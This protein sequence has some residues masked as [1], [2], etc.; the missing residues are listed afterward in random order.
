[1]RISSSIDALAVAR[2]ES[3]V[4]AARQRVGQLEAEG[5]RILRWGLLSAAAD[6]ATME[7]AA[8][9][10]G[11]SG[12]S[13]GAPAERLAAS[14][15]GCHVA[16]VIPTGLGAD[17]GGFVGDAGPVVRALEAVADTVI[18]NPNSVNGADFYGG[19][20]RS[21]YVEGWLLDQF[22]AGRATLRRTPAVRIGLLL[23]RLAPSVHHRLIDAANGMIAVRGINVMAVAA[24]SEALVADVRRSA[25]GHFIGTVGNLEVLLEP[26]R[27]LI[28]EGANCIAVCTDI[29]GITDA[30]WSGHYAGND[31]NPVGAIEALI[32]RSLSYLLGVPCVHAPATLPVVRDEV[33]QADARAASELASG[34]GLPCLLEGLSRVGTAAPAGMPAI[35][36]ADLAAVIVP[37]G[38][39]GGAPA[40][41]AL[42]H[43]VPIIVVR[44]NSCRVGTDWRAAGLP[45]A[46]VIE[47]ESYAEAIG[48]VAAI[49]AGLAPAAIRRPLRALNQ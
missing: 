19:G 48:L 6:R 18:T 3:A 26:A 1:M 17:T 24:S 44:Q 45:A 47:V 12:S 16:L 28:A 11:P 34:T 36:V 43:R 33:D 38:C 29:G 46:A 35:G 37:G 22:F 5:Q 13:G 8:L 40:L 23:D 32:S 14:A 42:E 7:V 10:G 21:L 15:P 9:E 27:Q 31:V 25:L 30:D 49:K 20:E 41:G 4:A 2:G 39:V